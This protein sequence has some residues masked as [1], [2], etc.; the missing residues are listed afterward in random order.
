MVGLV[1][2]VVTF[3]DFFGPFAG[4]CVPVFAYTHRAKILLQFG[5]Y[6]AM[7]MMLS[8][9]GLESFWYIHWGLWYTLFVFFLSR[10]CKLFVSG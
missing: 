10:V 6:K 4:V 1:T 7:K 3:P 2:S 9:D 5:M 8:I